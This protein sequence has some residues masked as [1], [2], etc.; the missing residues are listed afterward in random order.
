MNADRNLL[1]VPML[2]A[3]LLLAVFASVY[4]KV[5]NHIDPRELPYELPLLFVVYMFV[6]FVSNLQ[7]RSWWM[8][9][10]PAY[11]LVQSL[12]MPWTGACTYVVLAYRRGR[13]GRYR[14]GYRRRIPPA[15]MARLR[16][17]RIARAAA[18]VTA[19]RAR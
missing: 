3:Y 10:F 12:V 11:A 18:A 16:V 7:V 9:V 17:E 8:V 4:F 2:T 15:T 5:W 13:L 19:A 6:T 1:H 14:Y